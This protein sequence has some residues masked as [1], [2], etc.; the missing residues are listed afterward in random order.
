MK[1]KKEPTSNE[2]FFLN[3]SKLSQYKKSDLINK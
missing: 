1:M 2:E 3:A